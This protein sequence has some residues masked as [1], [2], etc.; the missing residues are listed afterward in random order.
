MNITRATPRLLK[1]LQ[2]AVTLEGGTEGRA[3]SQSSAISASSA[4][5]PSLAEEM[6]TA[7]GALSDMFSGYVA[8]DRALLDKGFEDLVGVI[9]EWRD[10]VP[11]AP[12]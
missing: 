8:K 2:N 10:A 9:E 7:L 1:R 11:K 12:R 6:D 3:N 5:E 4:D